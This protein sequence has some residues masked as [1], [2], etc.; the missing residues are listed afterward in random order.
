MLAS[1]QKQNCDITAKNAF[2]TQIV[3]KR[4]NVTSVGQKRNPRRQREL[5]TQMFF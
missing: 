3:E 4:R 5:E 1:K 2:L